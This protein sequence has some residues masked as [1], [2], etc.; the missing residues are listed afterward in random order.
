MTCVWKRVRINVDVGIR[1][2][3][4]ACCCSDVSFHNVCVND[5]TWPVAE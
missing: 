2:L 4:T 3:Q 5:V 1:P